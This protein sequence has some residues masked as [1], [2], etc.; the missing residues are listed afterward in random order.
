MNVIERHRTLVTYTLAWY[1]DIW[2]F[3]RGRRAETVDKSIEFWKSGDIIQ[4]L[5]TTAELL[6]WETR[7]F[8]SI[9]EETEDIEATLTSGD[10]KTK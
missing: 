4:G 2:N 10:T 3:I 7:K 6:F 9:A 8:K 1:S 5:A